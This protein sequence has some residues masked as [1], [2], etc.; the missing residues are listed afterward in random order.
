MKTILFSLSVFLLLLKLREKGWLPL[1]CVMKIVGPRIGRVVDDKNSKGL[2]VK[3]V[4]ES[5]Y[6]FQNIVGD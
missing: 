6:V 3:I 1:C 4:I 2:T 5:R